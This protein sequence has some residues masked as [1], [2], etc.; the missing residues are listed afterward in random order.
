MGHSGRPVTI[1]IASTAHG[2]IGT[3]MIITTHHSFNPDPW[4]WFDTNSALS[5][6]EPALVREVRGPG[7]L[8]GY[9]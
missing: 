9:R 8:Q 7:Q 3:I 6:A 5:L 4:D 1:A 2:Q